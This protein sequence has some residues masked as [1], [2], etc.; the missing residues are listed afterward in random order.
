MPNP[1]K[2][3]EHYK[4]IRYHMWRLQNALNNAHEAEVINYDP[5]KFNEEAPCY[6]MAQLRDRVEKTTAIT[7]AQ[8][9]KDEVMSELKDVW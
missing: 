7:R 2:V 4:K 3:R 9:F 6:T 5:G 1:K 8:A